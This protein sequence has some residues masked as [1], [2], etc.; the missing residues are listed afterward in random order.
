[1][2]V[3]GDLLRSD[4]VKGIYLT[5]DHRGLASCKINISFET[6]TRS[7]DNGTKQRVAWPRSETKHLCMPSGRSIHSDQAMAFAQVVTQTCRTRSPS[8]LICA[9]AGTLFCKF[10]LGF[11][12]TPSHDAFRPSGKMRVGAVIERRTVACRSSASC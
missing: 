11:G 2:L 9:R 3:I 1:V 4:I 6:R 5:I 12:V 10:L 8:R 7:V